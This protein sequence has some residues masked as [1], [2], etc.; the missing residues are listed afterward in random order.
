MGG[1]DENHGGDSAHPDVGQPVHRLWGQ[2]WSLSPDPQSHASLWLFVCFSL[3][4]HHTPVTSKSMSRAVE[5]IILLLC[6][7]CLYVSL[8]LAV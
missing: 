8:C 3:P 7:L 4:D 5:N 1:V 2:S 6:M